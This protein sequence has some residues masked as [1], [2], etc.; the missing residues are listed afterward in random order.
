[1]TRVESPGCSFQRE[2]ANSAFSSKVIEFGLEYFLVRRGGIVCICFNSLP[3]SITQLY[4]STHTMAKGTSSSSAKPAAVPA[5][6]PS[7]T[8]NAVESLWK[9]YVENTPPRLKLVDSFLV[10]IMLSG[11]AQFAYC[12]LVTNFPFNAFLAGSAASVRVFVA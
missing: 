6:L 1:M 4:T 8:V 2:P 11:I 3:L 9:T 12:I 5:P 10:F 7:A